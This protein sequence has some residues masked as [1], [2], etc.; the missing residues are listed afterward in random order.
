MNPSPTRR[1]PYHATLDG[2]TPEEASGAFLPTVKNPSRPQ[3]RGS[4]S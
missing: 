1:N 2:L 4:E 3:P